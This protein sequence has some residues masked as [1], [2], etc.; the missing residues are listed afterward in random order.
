[1]K[2]KR[3]KNPPRTVG[4]QFGKRVVLFKGSLVAIGM[5]LDALGNGL[6]LH[7]IEPYKERK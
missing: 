7:K 5:F 4:I 6:E 1:M 2:K 3:L